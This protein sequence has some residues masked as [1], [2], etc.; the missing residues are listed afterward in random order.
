MKAKR[1]LAFILVI[2]MTT[3]SGCN[4]EVE[5]TNTKPYDYISFDKTDWGMTPQEALKALNV[6][7][8]DVEIIPSTYF[9]GFYQ[10]YRLNLLKPVIIDDLEVELEL[11]F[12]NLVVDEKIV[13]ALGLT[14]VNVTYPDVDDDLYNLLS[15][16]YRKIGENHESSAKIGIPT[17][18]YDNMP[19]ELAKKIEDFYNR[20]DMTFCDESKHIF[21][22]TSLVEFN[23]KLTDLTI[24][25]NIDYNGFIVALA[26]YLSDNPDPAI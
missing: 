15:D 5:P 26:K 11:V 6:N 16:K 20:R 17:T 2:S 14:D 4:N 21:G 10:S 3:L 8:D 23:H 25:V 13:A 18:T 1:I 22:I 9:D 12:Q 19:S 24:S 7:F